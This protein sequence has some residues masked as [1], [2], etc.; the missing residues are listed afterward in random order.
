[1]TAS[2]GAGSRGNVLRDIAAAQERRAKAFGQWGAAF[3]SVLAARSSVADF[4]A[5]ADV[6]TQELGAVTTEMRRLQQVA[7]DAAP[8]SGPAA[9]AVAYVDRLQNQERRRYEATVETQR[10]LARHANSVHSHDATCPVL[11]Y[12]PAEVARVRPAEP[13]MAVSSDDDDDAKEGDDAAE[14]HQHGHC[15]H[16]GARQRPDA[17]DD[18]GVDVDNCQSIRSLVE[19]QSN[20]LREATA[21]VN[22]LCEELQCELS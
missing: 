3:R 17:A 10:C 8:G 7:K 5:V 14:G 20:E 2:G 6:V 22:D 1:M 15:C 18:D 19:T 21:E 12:L 9:F 4:Q 16:H 11:T 13:A